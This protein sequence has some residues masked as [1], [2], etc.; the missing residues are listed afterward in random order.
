VF[1][2]YY[3]ALRSIH[4]GAV[5]ASGAL[6]A[7]R[8]LAFNLAGAAWPLKRPV[9]LL[10]YAVDTTLLVAA[11]MLTTIVRQYPFVDGWVTTK[12][13]LLIVYIVL[14]Y[15]ALR[16]PSLTARMSCLA[17][18]VVTFLFIVTVARAHDPLG[19]FAGWR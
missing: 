9:R 11:V 10:A 5:I 7:G 15:R 19:L 17:G 16:G 12:V 13:L 14:G 3:L 18:A 8:A 6:F 1:D 4:I 2:A